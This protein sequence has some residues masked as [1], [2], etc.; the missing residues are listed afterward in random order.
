MA[1]YEERLAQD[2]DALRERIRSVGERVER[3]FD[4]AIRA[5]LTDDRELAAA[6]VLGDARVNRQIREIDRLCHAFVARHLPSAG[7]LRFVSAVLRLNVE[8]ERIGDYAST[9]CR[10]QLQLS[11]PPSRAAARDIEMI[12]DQARRVLHQAL[13]VFLEGNADLARGTMGMADQVKDTFQNVF[14]DLLQ[15][16]ERSKRPLKDLFALLVIFNRLGRVS[17][18]AKNI[19][20]ETVFAVTGETKAPKVYPIL[21]IDEKNDALSQMAE[22]FARRA[23]PESGRYSSAGWNPAQQLDPGVANFMQS[24]SFDLEGM[25]PKRLVTVHDDL[26]EWYVVVSLE[27]GAREQIP[28]V[29]YHTLLLEWDPGVGP[30]EA[31]QWSEEALEEAFRTLSVKIG[32][33]METLRGKGAS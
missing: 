9:I 30:D 32:E 21:F 12:A 10:E 17:D 14:R 22:A 5:I 1:Y 2:L 25:G 31:G 13:N 19:C 3:A 18:Q 33:L 27:P 29:P 28:E 7:H 23:Y 8:L 26:E 4:S 16:G 6:T 20:E 15:E 24:K 11:S